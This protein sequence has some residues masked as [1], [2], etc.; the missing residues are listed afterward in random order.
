MY[1]RSVLQRW[2]DEGRV[3]VDGDRATRRTRVRAGQRIRVDP[4]APPPM[5]AEAQDLPL[6][7][8]YED[9]DVLVVD[10]AAG[11]VVHPAAGH[12]QGTLVNA[13]LHHLGVAVSTGSV[14]PGIVHRLDKDTSGLMVIG[15]HEASTQSLLEAFKLRQVWRA[16]WALARGWLAS[17]GTFDTPYGRHPRDRKRFSGRVSSAR[18][19]VTHYAVL[20]RLHACS[21][22]ECR[23]ET[24][25][26][27]QIRVHFAESGAPLLGDLVYGRL[28][29][30]PRLRAVSKALGRQALHARVLQFVHPRTGRAVRLESSLPADLQAARAALAT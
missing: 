29:S 28:P 7:V 13:V 27:H 22:V 18:R 20:D 15:K 16:Y 24:G 11:V 3:R 1:T 19:A 25:R 30:D 14:R 2:L 21:E 8:L 10:K 17:A 12:A 9:D 5:R 23:L 26:T 4:Q 6:S